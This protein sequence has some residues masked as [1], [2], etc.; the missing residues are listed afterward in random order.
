VDG[1]AELSAD[2]GYMGQLTHP[3]VMA[4]ITDTLACIAASG[5]A[6]GILSTDKAVLDAAMQAGARFVAVGLDSVLLARGAR[7]LA[8]EWVK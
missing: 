8:A 6:P 3:E 5:K 7:A 4:T 1:P 2:M